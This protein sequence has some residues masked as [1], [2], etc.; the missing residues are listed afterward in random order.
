MGNTFL[1]VILLYKSSQNILIN[2]PFPVR[3]LLKFLHCHPVFINSSYAKHLHVENVHVTCSG[4]TSC[5]IRC[6]KY[7]N[8][9]E[10]SIPVSFIVPC[11]TTS[12]DSKWATMKLLL[13]VNVTEPLLLPFL[14]KSLFSLRGLKSHLQIQ[15]ASVMHDKRVKLPDCNAILFAFCRRG[16]DR[17]E[18][19]RFIINL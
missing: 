14:F 5:S 13:S 8:T 18:T 6:T 7:H 17:L 15:D 12:L 19:S 16:K 9:E 10:R 3:W 1:A 4:T 11:L 2:L